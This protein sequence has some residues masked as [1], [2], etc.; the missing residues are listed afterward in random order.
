[1]P[2]RLLFIVL[3]LAT[4]VGFGPRSSAA[5]RYHSEYMPAPRQDFYCLQGRIWGYPGNCQF[6]S[7][8][9][10]ATSASGTDAYCGMNPFYAFQQHSPP[11]R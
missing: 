8:S 10:C 4:V 3:A 5:P 1:M 6:S 2:Y 7:Y 11:F 9:Q